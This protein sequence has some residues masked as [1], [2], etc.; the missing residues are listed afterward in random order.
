MRAAPPAPAR[1]NRRQLL[2]A[3]AGLC[4]APAGALAQG[5]GRVVLPSA[6]SLADEVAAANRD[7]QPLVVLVSLAGCPFCR[8]ARDRYL[9]PL[10]DE[11]GTPVV[12]VDMG[13]TQAVRGFAGQPLTHDRLIKAWSI[14]LAPTVLF[15]RPGGNEIA[16]R[17]VG[18]SLSDFYGAYLDGRLREARGVVRR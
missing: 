10:R 13:S 3:A 5:A 14:D 17:L 6:V 9:G 7:G 11:Q 18:G 16:P 15:F 1:S 4:L 12:Q 8:A 2:L